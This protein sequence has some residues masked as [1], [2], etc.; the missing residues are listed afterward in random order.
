MAPRCRH[1]RRRFHLWH[2]GSHRRYRSGCRSRLPQSDARSAARIS[3]IQIASRH[4]RN[5]GGRKDDR[6]RRESDSGGRLLLDAAHVRRR[7]HDRGRLGRLSQRRPPQ[8]HSPRHQIGDAGGGN[9]VS[10][11]AQRKLFRDPASGVRSALRKFMVARRAVAAAK[12]PSSIRV[13]CNPWHGQ[14]GIGHRDEGAR[15]RSHESPR[16]PRRTRADGTY[17]T[18]LLG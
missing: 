1:V 13:R 8:R 17:P 4:P 5:S 2:E 12:L 6:G 10:R 7:L 14:C 11:A 3:A 9:G 16:R 15:L 18:L